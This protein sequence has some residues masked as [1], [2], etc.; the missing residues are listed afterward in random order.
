[1]FVFVLLGG[2]VWAEAPV[3]SVVGRWKTVDDKTGETMSVVQ[4]VER[5]G[6]VSGTIVQVAPKP[7]VS[8][9]QVCKRCTGALKDR[10]IVGLPLIDGLQRVGDAWDNGTIVDPSS[11]TTYRCR[12][13]VAKD[14]ASLEVRGYVGIPLFGRSQTWLR[15][16][17]SEPPAGAR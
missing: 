9:E 16:E 8:G 15:V 7:G 5:D 6:R 4:L 14:G 3:Q 10:P 13:T 11:G 2:L 12:V 1:V 17:S